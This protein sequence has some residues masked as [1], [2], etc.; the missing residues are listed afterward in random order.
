MLCSWTR[1]AAE[2]LCVVASAQ[3][4]AHYRAK[5]KIF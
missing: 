4:A 1:C 3:L 5:C 2:V